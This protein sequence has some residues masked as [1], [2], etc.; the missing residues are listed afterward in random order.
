LCPYQHH[1]PGDIDSVLYQN[2]NG[3]PSN[4]IDIPS[5]ESKLH[6]TLDAPFLQPIIS[7]HSGCSLF[8]LWMLPFCNLQSAV[9]PSIYDIYQLW[10]TWNAVYVRNLYA[11]F[12][13]LPIERQS[14]KMSL[15][16]TLSK[17]RW[18]YTS[19]GVL[20]FNGLMKQLVITTDFNL[21]HI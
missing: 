9:L 8:A 19:K 7:L 1:N 11:N 6:C 16:F 14:A 10:Y 17:A 15:T 12:F 5:G 4:G 18:F 21:I 3:T 2:T 20:Q 13:C